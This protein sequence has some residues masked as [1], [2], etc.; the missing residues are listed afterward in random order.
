[1]VFGVIKGTEYWTSAEV[2]VGFSAM[3]ESVEMM[4][5]GESTSYYIS[6]FLPS[7]EIHIV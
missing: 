6:L 7:A 5:F 2:V 4:F 1:M 3:L